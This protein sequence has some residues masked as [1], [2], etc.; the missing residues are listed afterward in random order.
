[1]SIG[2][3]TPDNYCA[4]PYGK[5]NLIIIYEGSQLEMV[6]TKR[7]AMQ[8]IEN[9]RVANPKTGTVTFK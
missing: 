8:F 2:F 7:Q 4:V 6:K 5:N 1:M 3:I 9:H